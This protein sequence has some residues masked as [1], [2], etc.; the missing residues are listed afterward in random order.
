MELE[1]QLAISIKEEA[2]KLITR[3]HEYHN[4]VHIESKRNEKRLGDSAPTKEIHIPDY[5][6][7]DK[8]QI[9][10]QTQKY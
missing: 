5:W 10:L 2:E 7:H 3:Y 9:Y 1:K 6:S 8:K 4:R